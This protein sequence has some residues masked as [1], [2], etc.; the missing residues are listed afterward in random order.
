MYEVTITASALT[1]SC[2][3]NFICG[4]FGKAKVNEN[5][6]LFIECFREPAALVA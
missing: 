5:L 2:M 3:R 1:I 6:F 4:S